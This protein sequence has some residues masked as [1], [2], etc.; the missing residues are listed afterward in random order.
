MAIEA[1]PEVESVSATAA[2]TAHHETFLESA[3]ALAAESE[4]GLPMAFEMALTRQHK[5]PLKLTLAEMA[6]VRLTAM[7]EGPA[8]ALIMQKN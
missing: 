3:V 7:L 4:M 5:L 8:V 2:V 1:L 6:A